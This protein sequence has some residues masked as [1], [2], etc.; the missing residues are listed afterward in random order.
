MSSTAIL[1]KYGWKY[2]GRSQNY[3]IDWLSI[4]KMLFLKKLVACF[5]MAKRS[6]LLIF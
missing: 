6:C 1:A 2:K 5:F 3:T 4:R